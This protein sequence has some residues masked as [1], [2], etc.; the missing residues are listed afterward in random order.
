MWFELVQSWRREG[1]NVMKS[2]VSIALIVC[3]ASLV[4]APFLF[5]LAAV[6]IAANVMRSTSGDAHF[7]TGLDKSMQ[8]TASIGGLIMVLLGTVGAFKSKPSH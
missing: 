2:V 8:W 5:N 3:G 1:E 4:L 6:G 7:S